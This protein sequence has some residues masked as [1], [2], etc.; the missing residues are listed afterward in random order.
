M[1]RAQSAKK[2]KMSD[3]RQGISWD[4]REALARWINTR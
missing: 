4:D 3:V 2:E 1:S